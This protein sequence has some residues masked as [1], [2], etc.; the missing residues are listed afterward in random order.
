MFKEILRVWALIHTPTFT[1]LSR[2]TNETLTT[3][4]LS[5]FVKF[6]HQ[7]EYKASQFVFAVVDNFM[8]NVYSSPFDVTWYG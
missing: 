1:V 4:T 7:A 3:D 2:T 8:L 5:V 6:L